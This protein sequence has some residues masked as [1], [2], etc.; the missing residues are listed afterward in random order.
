MESLFHFE[1]IHCS[2]EEEPLNRALDSEDKMRFLGAI[3]SSISGT[4]KSQYT[5]VGA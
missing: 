2:E 3:L 1:L 4:L 5:A